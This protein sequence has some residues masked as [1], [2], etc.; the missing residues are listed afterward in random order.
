L[1]KND[2]LTLKG[3]EEQISLNIQLYEK[4]DKSYSNEYPNLVLGLDYDIDETTRSALLNH[5]VDLEREVAEYE[6]KLSVV[7]PHVAD[8]KKLE[9]IDFFE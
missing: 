6:S 9:T 3:Q 8:F 5:S 4:K 1:S 7:L 2:L